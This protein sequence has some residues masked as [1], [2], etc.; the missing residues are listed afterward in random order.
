MFNTYTLIYLT[1]MVAKKSKRSGDVIR[2]SEI[3]QYLYCPVAWYLH[4]CGY[5]PQ[6][7][8]LEK[9][10]QVHEAY[11]HILE[12]ID[13]KNQLSKRCAV[14]GYLF[15]CVL[16]LLILYGVLTWYM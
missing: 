12:G 1:E 2:A 13:Q 15:L 7:P 16:I 4:R 5:Q 10:V 3:G 8:L 6:S 9:G 14:I 11:G